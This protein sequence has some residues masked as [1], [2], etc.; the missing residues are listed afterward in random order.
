VGAGDLAEGAPTGREW[1]LVQKLEQNM[2]STQPLSADEYPSGYADYVGRV[3]GG[4]DVVEVLA[5][6]LEE[7]SS[8]LAGIPEARGG[9]RY[10]AGKWS[11]KEVVGHLSDVERIMV[12]RALRFARGD[13]APLAGF[14]ENAYVPEAGADTRSLA[15]LIGEWVTVRQA[16][17]AFFQGLPPGAWARRGVANA[18]PVTVRA[19]AY[20]VA[21]HEHH[22]LEVLRTRY[23]LWD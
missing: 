14:D 23:R 8:L 10:A 1:P 4:A 15:S 6:Q 11:V 3:P 9:F 17:L 22:H 12:Y 20:V 5:R 2:P 19:L 13:A 7:T 16:S 18:N 21:G